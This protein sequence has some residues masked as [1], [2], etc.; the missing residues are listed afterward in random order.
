V[1]LSGAR[2]V[3]GSW[4]RDWDA[5]LAQYSGG[6]A[7]APQRFG[8]GKYKRIEDAPGRYVQFRVV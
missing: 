1:W 3:K 2:E 8:G 6:E 7:P 4:W 5:W